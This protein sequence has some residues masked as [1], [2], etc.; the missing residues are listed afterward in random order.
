MLDE[1]L[2]GDVFA[3]ALVFARLG[4]AVMLLPGFG[5]N[6]VSPRIRLLIALALTVVVTPVVSSYLPPMPTGLLAA[7]ILVAGEVLIGLFLGAMVRMLISALHIAG[8]I[9]GCQTSLANATF[10]DPSNSQQGAIFAA[11]LN[12]IGT[13]LIFVTD[14]HHLMLMA[15][16]DSYTLFRPG[17]PLPLGDFSHVVVRVLA[18]SFVL[19]LQLSAPFIVIAII[20]YTGL[21]LLARLM[22]QI[23]VFFIAI[24]LQI[25]LAF[26]VL[27]M[28]LSAGMFWFLSHFQESLTRITGQ[29]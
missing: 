15:I 8:V 20:F 23:Q 28:T 2:T 6:F 19:G 9:I 7:F 24:P 27:A 29:G 18:E 22:P 13:F 26:S 4:A 17:A 10:F 16:A 3:L 21:G 25:I 12:I 1:L 5:E 14:L 11:F